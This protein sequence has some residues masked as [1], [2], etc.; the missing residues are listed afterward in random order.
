MQELWEEWRG[1]AS[2][3]RSTMEERGCPIRGWIEEE[4]GVFIPPP[5]ITVAVLG[6]LSGSSRGGLSGLDRKH[7]HKNGDNFCIQTP[8]LMILARWNHHNELYNFI[9]RNIIVQQRRAKPN[10][11]RFDLSIKMNR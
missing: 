8:F 7:Q 4:E 6:G 11:K 10:D 2:Y 3:S 1:R 5:K 9:H